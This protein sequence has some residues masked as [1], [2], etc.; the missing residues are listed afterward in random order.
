[1]K[2]A[3]QPPPAS[4]AQNATKP[5]REHARGEAPR[6]GVVVITRNRRASLLGTLR[7]LRELPERPPVV[8]VDNGST[9]GTADA[10]R[11]DFPQVRLVC[12]GRN[13]G[14]VG[15]THGAAAL[16]TPYVAFSD[17]DS[18]WE[19]G[20]L[21]RAADLLDAHPRL[22]LIA[23]ATRVGPHGLPDPLND[24]LL[25]SP[26]GRDPDLPGPGVLGFLACAAVLRRTAFLSVGGFHPVLHFGAEETLL[27]LDLDARHWG[28]AHCPDV[29]ARHHPDEQPRLGRTVRV[30]RNEVL[31]AWLRRPLRHAVGQTARLMADCRRDAEARAALREAAQRLPA[32]LAR[33]R[34]L[35]PRVERRVR[36]L[37]RGR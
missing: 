12:P 31:T 23:A 17:D 36:L 35:P 27:A 37:E 16:T 15:R 22:A 3:T 26:L 28:V 5:T 1:M 7:Q 8:V 24:A 29:I 21:R 13:L 20:A 2:P 25:N 4:T 19:P 30:R 14:A 11:R 18:W 34:R 6:V 9:D 33:R 10:V 32:A